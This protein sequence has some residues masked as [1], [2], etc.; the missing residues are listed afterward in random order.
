MAAIWREVL[1]GCFCHQDNK[2]REEKFYK[3]IST[4]SLD[5]KTQTTVPSEK[6]GKYKCTL[7]GNK[8]RHTLHPYFSITVEGVCKETKISHEV[9]FH[10]QSSNGFR[11][12]V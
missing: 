8:G 12:N 7:E 1:R 5:P 9:S 3:E 2:L 6:N 10:K 11:E 4:I